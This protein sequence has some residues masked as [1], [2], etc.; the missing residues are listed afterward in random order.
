[1][2]SALPSAAGRPRQLS[3]LALLHLAVTLETPLRPPPLDHLL[4][5]SALPA[6]CLERE[7]RRRPRLAPLLE[8][9]RRQEP[10]ACAELGYPVPYL[11]SASVLLSW[12]DGRR[13]AVEL[14]DRDALLLGA[15]GSDGVSGVGGVT[16]DGDVTVPGGDWRNG[17]GTRDIGGLG[18][19]RSLGPSSAVGLVRLKAR[20]AEQLG[21]EVWWDPG[22]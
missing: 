10:A 22:L 21:Y 15:S 16:E 17:D 19:V 18:D 2:V 1:M 5:P 12:S 7:L 8:R 4:T 3:R 9:L 13:A 11:N 20:L 14:L 6:P